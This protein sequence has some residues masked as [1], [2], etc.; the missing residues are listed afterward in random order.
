MSFDAWGD[1][2]VDDSCEACDEK[3][4]AIQQLLDSLRKTLAAAIVLHEEGIGCPECP[5]DSEDTGADCPMLLAAEAA[6]AKVEKP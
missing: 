5:A 6:I 3:D 1:D 4:G 2:D